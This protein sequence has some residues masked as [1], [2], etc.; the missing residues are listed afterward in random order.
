M[1]GCGTLSA[2]Y[3]TCIIVGCLNIFSMLS[4]T[5]LFHG[6]CNGSP[7]HLKF[8]WIKQFSQEIFYFSEVG[9]SIRTS[10]ESVR[11]V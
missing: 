11:I 3:L 10:D 9:P 4:L 1:D 8:N 2:G 5:M 7:Y 6:K